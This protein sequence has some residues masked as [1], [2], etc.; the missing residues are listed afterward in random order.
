MAGQL[1][2]ACNINSALTEIDIRNFAQ[3]MYFLKFNSMGTEIISN[4]IKE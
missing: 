1:L 2:H 4:F 3:G